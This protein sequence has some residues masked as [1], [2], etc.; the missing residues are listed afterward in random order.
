MKSNKHDNVKELAKEIENE[1]AI[2]INCKPII[3]L[4]LIHTII[5]SN[6]SA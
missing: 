2:D 4:Y 6:T 5:L 1:L 3:M